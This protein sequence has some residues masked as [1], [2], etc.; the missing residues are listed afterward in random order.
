[1]DY[2]KTIEDIIFEQEAVELMALGSLYEK[3][4]MM[5]SWYME[6]ETPSAG[7]APTVDNVNAFVRF[8][9]WIGR[10]ITSIRTKIR[11]SISNNRLKR[12][13][14][15]IDELNDT[16]VIKIPT[17]A[18]REINRLYNKLLQSGRENSIAEIET[19]VEKRNYQKMV[20]SWKNSLKEYNTLNNA[21]INVDNRTVTDIGNSKGAK[22]Q[23]KSFIDKTIGIVDRL[24][25]IA[26][27][28]NEIIK[29]EK[30]KVT[31]EVVK[32]NNFKQWTL[33]IS[34][35][36][37]YCFKMIK[38][39]T[40]AIL[41]I[42]CYGSSPSSKINITQ[43]PKGKIMRFDFFK[44]KTKSII[45]QHVGH[46]LYWG[47]IDLPIDLGKV[48]ND[49]LIDFLA[50]IQYHV[51]SGFLGA[52]SKGDISLVEYLNAQFGNDEHE[53][54][55]CLVGIIMNDKDYAGVASVFV[56]NDFD[57]EIK[58]KVKGGVIYNDSGN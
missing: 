8:V 39:L 53:K 11:K 51:P 30:E 55:K 48:K 14:A 2:N 35:C 41:D 23:L 57:E 56:A 10:I 37:T 47:I 22:D 16:Q 50:N 31:D 27:K 28:S 6:E 43:Y 49:K 17:T 42:L 21:L 4:L 5:E 13:R 46:D 58:N 19:F 33:A 40:D 24:S 36:A 12:Y 52:S 44:E 29:Q 32:S 38:T 26:E 54:N 18:S 34:R 25:K 15:H 20:D 3:Q 9:N 45:R 7:E 1:M